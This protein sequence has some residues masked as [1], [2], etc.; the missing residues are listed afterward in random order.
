MPLTHVRARLEGEIGWR[1]IT[2]EEAC[3]KYD[4]TVPARC[5]YFECE[6]C[7]ERVG[8]AKAQTR[9]FFHEHSNSR[10][11]EDRQ[12]QMDSYER[13]YVHSL[14]SHT[15]PL[16][17]ETHDET[18][19]LKIGFF[20]PPN[21]AKCEMI[22]ITGKPNTKPFQYSFER[23]LGKGISYLSVGDVPSESYQ[24][25]YIDAESGLEE[26]WPIEIPGV[27]KRSGAFFDC[28][29]DQ[30]MI[31]PGGRACSGYT[32][33]FLHCDPIYFNL[34]PD[35]DWIEVAKKRINSNLTWHLYRVRAKN[36][37][38]NAAD[39]FMRYSVY[40]R[41]KP[42]DFYPI[43]PVY[44]RDPYFIYHNSD[45]IFLYLQ[46][47]DMTLESYP[48]GVASRVTEIQDDAKIYR[49][50]TQ[51]KE[52]LVSIGR[53]GLL[54]FAYLMR[55]QL[56][57]TIQPPKIMLADCDGNELKD[58]TYSKIPR[59]KY[60][61][62]RCNYDGRA[63]AQ[64]NGKIVRIYE[65]TGGEHLIID[66]LSFGTEI[67][68]YQGLDCVRT[69]RFEQEVTAEETFN[70]EVL[71]KRLMSRKEPMIPVTHAIAVIASGYAK[72]PKTKRWLYATIRQ[73]KISRKALKLLK[74]NAQR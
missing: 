47:D 14:S 3:K 73:G 7:G 1:H 53:S 4:Y 55:R 16:R 32:Y 19:E 54:G 60:I 5:D 62:V 31:R 12:I 25:E 38:R 45:Y 24:L 67:D 68:F 40:L 27:N 34:F 9:Y 29:H 74:D 13:N 61:S 2:I 37:S 15:M 56:G 63:V 21:S 48:S 35:I 58:E 18:F 6:L 64:R 51:E 49:L 46:G 66:S 36:F 41:E 65:L 59:R 30:R 52:Q 69:I 11:C 43:W 57:K 70:D 39:F 17:I 10:D 42:S 50:R 33:Y 28:A 71:V 20:Y 26:Y 8:L 23:I 72:Y 22:K 44:V